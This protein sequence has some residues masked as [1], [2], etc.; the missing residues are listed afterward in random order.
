VFR[1]CRVIGEGKVYLGRAWN[2]F[3]RVYF[4]D[5]F[6]SDVVEPEGWWAWNNVGH[7]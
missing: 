6:L 5:S 3:S 7:E 2:A 1:G 4:V